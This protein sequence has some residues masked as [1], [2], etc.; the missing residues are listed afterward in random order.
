MHGMKDRMLFIFIYNWHFGHVIGPSAFSY[1]HVTNAQLFIYDQMDRCNALTVA[2]CRQSTEQG[3]D[4]SRC[5]GPRHR[6]PRASPQPSPSP[7]A[8]TATTTPPPPSTAATAA[9]A[10]QWW[11]RWPQLQ[12]RPGGGVPADRGEPGHQ[13]SAIRYKMWT[14]DL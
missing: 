3:S 7:P 12:H 5:R 14:A 2:W 4:C 9:T 11:R 6:P 1:K 13:V 10:A 8:A